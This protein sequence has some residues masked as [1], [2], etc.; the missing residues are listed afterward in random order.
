MS[1]IQQLEEIEKNIA[2]ALEF[3]GVV[4]NEMA[5]DKS[6]SKNVE[7][8]C[9]QFAKALENVESGL[10]SQINYLTTV[11]TSQP[12]TGSSYGAQKDLLLAC[13]RN[14]IIK[15]RLQE[16]EK[17]HASHAKKFSN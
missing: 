17:V 15:N 13:Q 3:A 2:K 8:H 10:M 16:L 9:T 6:V 4:M 1:R 5:K 7:S 12:H 14:E 11:S